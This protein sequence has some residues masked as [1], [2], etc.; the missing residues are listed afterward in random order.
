[1]TDVRQ[2]DGQTTV[3][4]APETAPVADW[5]TDY[6]VLDPGYVAE[7]YPIWDRLRAEC[8]VA[9]S[10]RWGGSW[11][12]TR[13]ADVVAVAHDVEHFSSRDVGVIGGGE[14][15]EGMPDIG[16]PAD[17]RRSA[18][19]HVGPPADPAVVLTPSRR[20]LRVDDARPL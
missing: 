1:M 6:D 8:P 5:A 4:S 3:P 10:E 16:A 20:E 13:Y 14:P 11:M 7:P 18:T 17:R 9:R 2:E 12:P 15:L 19:A